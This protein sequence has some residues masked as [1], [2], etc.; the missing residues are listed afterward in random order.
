MNDISKCL[1]TN[2]T[3]L[4]LHVISP[5]S[6]FMRELNYPQVSWLQEY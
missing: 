6:F 2:L 3:K 5:I 4:L 1:P